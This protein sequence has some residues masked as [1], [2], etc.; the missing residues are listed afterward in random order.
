MGAALTFIVM[1]YK[2]DMALPPSVLHVN[3]VDTGDTLMKPQ[4][5]ETEFDCER[6]KTLMRELVRGFG[7][8]D[9]IVITC[10]NPPP[11]IEPIEEIP[12]DERY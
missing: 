2:Q 3:A 8:N 4:E 7:R 11:P 10:V 6:T 9:E 1:M 5:F 12:A